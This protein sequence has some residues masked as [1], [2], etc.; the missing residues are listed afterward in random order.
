MSTT[1]QT[2]KNHRAPAWRTV[3][4]AVREH[5]AARFDVIAGP[6]AGTYYLAAGDVAAALEGE[7]APVYEMKTRAGER[8]PV[9][10]GFVRTSES[11]RMLIIQTDAPARFM[12]PVIPF[13]AH[14]ANP[15]ANRA[16]K[17]TIPADELA[18]VPGAT[19]SPCMAVPA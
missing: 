11:G 8:V 4:I 9:E 17:I 16:T 1:T 12:V 7:I 19:S 10:A 13:M 6:A 18:P 2:L 3:G 5:A 15:A 14:Y